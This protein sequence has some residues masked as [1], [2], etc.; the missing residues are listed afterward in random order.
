MRS[1]FTGICAAISATA[2]CL[3][4][5]PTASNAMIPEE[6]LTRSDFNILGL[7]IGE[8]HSTSKGGSYMAQIHYFGNPGFIKCTTRKSLFKAEYG[9]LKAIHAGDPNAHNISQT[10]KDSFLDLLGAVQPKEGHYCLMFERLQGDNLRD[11]AKSLKP[12][13][14]DSA[15]SNIFSHVLI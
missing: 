1:F 10:V 13:E 15:L 9:A 2:L 3:C 6:P 11:Y 8:E 4:H 5:F 14:K 12:Q 7:S